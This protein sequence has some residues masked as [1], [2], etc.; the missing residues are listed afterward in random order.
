MPPDPPAVPQFPAT[1]WSVVLLAAGSGTQAQAALEDLCRLYWFPIYCF[2][3]QQGCSPEDAEDET[4][5]FLSRAVSGQLL[6]SADPDKGHLRTHL[7]NAFQ[8]DLIDSRRRAGRVKRGGKIEFIALEALQAEDRFKSTPPLESPTATFD[9]AWSMTCLDTTVGALENEYAARGRASVF[10]SL[11]PFLDPGSDG[12][13][14]AASQATG[15]EANAIRQA[16]YRLRQRFRVLLRQ[17]IADTLENPTESLIDE[18]IAA[19]RAAL[20]S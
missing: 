3:R 6:T 15:L 18:E 1:R 19:L 20:V 4:Q 16:V 2:A 14:T 13:Y 9:R 5:E 12:D 8:C 7:L 10:Q 17:T 11:R